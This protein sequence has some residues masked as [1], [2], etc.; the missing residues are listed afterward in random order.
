MAPPPKITIE[1][2]TVQVLAD[3]LATDLREFLPHLGDNSPA[4]RGKGFGGPRNTNLKEFN[5]Y[6]QMG[7]VG[8][9]SEPGLRP[10][11]EAAGPYSKSGEDSSLEPGCRDIKLTGRE[12]SNNFRYI[13]KHFAMVAAFRRQPGRA[14]PAKLFY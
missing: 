3:F 14:E 9:Q 4:Q 10:K 8:E 2:S 6:H 5:I 7:P 13:I 11:V 1:N 12:G